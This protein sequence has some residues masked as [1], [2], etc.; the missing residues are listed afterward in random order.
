MK[1]LAL[2]LRPLGRVYIV[3]GDSRYAG[4][5][6]PVARIIA[7]IAQ[8]TGYAVLAFEPFRSMR[9]SPQQ[10]GIRELSETL[11]VLERQR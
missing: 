7:E 4:I 2:G 8:T 11:V 9:S 10:G 1:K 5:V 3:V 6:V